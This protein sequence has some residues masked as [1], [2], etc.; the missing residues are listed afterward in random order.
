M[1]SQSL[2]LDM[3]DVGYIN[4]RKSSLFLAT[5]RRIDHMVTKQRPTYK[6]PHIVSV[7]VVQY[8]EVIL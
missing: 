7:S 4:A 8:L 6:T 2:L 3:K 5:R 1:A